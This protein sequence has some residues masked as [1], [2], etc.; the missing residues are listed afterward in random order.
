M[1][2]IKKTIRRILILVFFCVMVYSGYQLY[3]IYDDY[4]SAD[5]AYESVADQFVTPLD[6]SE[7]FMD[8]GNNAPTLDIS[9]ET[10]PEA[11]SEVP[12]RVDFDALLAINPNVIGWIYCPD[13]SINYPI[14]QTGNNTDYMR[15]LLDG[16]YNRS[17]TL[18][19]D[20]RSDGTL[21][22]YN[23]V[24]YGHNMGSGKMFAPLMNYR[25]Q[26]YYEEHPVMYL[27]TPGGD[28][29]LEV[30]AG[31]VVNAES[32]YYIMSH[33]EESFQTF[34]TNIYAHSTFTSSV[35]LRT[36][37]QTLTLSTCPTINDSDRYILVCSLVPIQC[38]NPV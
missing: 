24:I 2:P 18:F 11:V 3:L 36:V 22:D 15:R 14:V 28:Y 34:L 9:G 1:S 23:A 37:A 13:T 35:D 7:E 38:K 5:E 20:Y 19:M 26:S 6:K 10:T 25:N 31:A 4:H 8:A 33:T 30:L 27:L 29:R 16:T 21:R 17:G 12:I 32:D